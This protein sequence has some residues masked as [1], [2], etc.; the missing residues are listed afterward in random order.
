LS[1]ALWPGEILIQDCRTTSIFAS[2]LRA[3]LEAVAFGTT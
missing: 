3:A 1:E 2:G